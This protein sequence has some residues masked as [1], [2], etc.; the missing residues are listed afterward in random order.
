VALS[1]FVY[2]RKVQYRETDA[3]GLAHF[4]A[5][6]AYAEEAEHAMWREAGLSVEPHESCIG[7]PRV[8][9][10]F[11]FRRALRFEDEVDVRLR[12]I[13]K[14]AKTLTYQAVILLDGTVAAIG[15]HTSIC[16]R[17][18]AGAP[19]KAIEMPERV[20]NAFTAVQPLP[21]P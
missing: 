19:I 5:F 20:A 3:S 14:T 12:V 11:E 4:T 13:G 9:A 15:Q 21:D 7:W 18:Q 8:S 17:K 10:S 1:E 2:R 16:V 6:F